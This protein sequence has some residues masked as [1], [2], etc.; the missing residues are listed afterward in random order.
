MV[1]LVRGKPNTQDLADVVIEQLE[2]GD[3]KESFYRLTEKLKEI[4]DFYDTGDLVG[5]QGARGPQGPAGPPGAT[6]GIPGP[7]GP[8]GSATTDKDFLCDASV[9][10]NAPVWL[11]GDGFVQTI[12]N[13]NSPGPIIGVVIDRPEVDT[14]TVRI[15]GL[16]DF[17][18]AR[19]DLWL[20]SSGTISTVRP[21]LG[22]VQRL[23]Y[24]FGDGT[25]IV[26]PDFQRSLIQT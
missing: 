6:V 26:Q 20:S 3:I 14:C 17:S 16:Y 24:S 11:A 19:G 5:P 10:L 21:T 25:I 15:F 1:D 9:P 4:F 7:E 22:F 18:F 13:N 8:A 12:T 2:E 23:G